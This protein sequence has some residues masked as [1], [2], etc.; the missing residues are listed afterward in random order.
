MLTKG[1]K[2][3]HNATLCVQAPTQAA[4]RRGDW[5]LQM[6]S[7]VDDSEEYDEVTLKKN[8]KA[9]AAAKAQPDTIEPCNLAS[10]EPE[11]VATMRAKLTE[12][13]KDTVQ[14]GHL[15]TEIVAPEL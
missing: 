7:S 6:N 8:A 10:R 4:L 12:M 5:K 1:E 13:L 11:H 3:P 9:K 15:G 2:S 14:P